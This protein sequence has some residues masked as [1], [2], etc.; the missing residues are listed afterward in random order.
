RARPPRVTRHVCAN[1][2]VTAD[3]KTSARAESAILLFTGA[4]APLVGIYHDQ[5]VMTEAGWL[6]NER[7]GA[8]T[9]GP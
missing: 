6:F 8:L 5:L 9:F 3:S 7:R 1:I 4:A 2:V